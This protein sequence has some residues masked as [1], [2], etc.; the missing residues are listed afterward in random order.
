MPNKL[1]SGALWYLKEKH[2][3]VIP[4]KADKKPYIPWEKYQ[5]EHPTEKQ[6]IE[7]WETY[8]D[9]NV[10]I[11]TGAISDLTV[12]DLDSAAGAIAFFEH[13]PSNLVCPT[14]KSPKG[15]HL[16][17]RY[18]DGIRN[19]ARFL[20]DCDIRSEGG[21]I[22]APPSGINGNTYSWVAGRSIKGTT[23]PDLP[24]SIINI[25]YSYIEGM[26]SRKSQEVTE[27]TGD[28]QSHRYW[29]PGRRDD[30]LFT[31]ANALIKTSISEEF[32]RQTLEILIKNL[33]DDLEPNK[34]DEKIKSAIKRVH[35][36]EV[37]VM[38]EVRQWV[39]SQEGHFR[40]TECHT[41]SQYV[42]KTQKHACLMAILRLVKEGVL[43]KYGTQRGVY[44]K[45]ENNLEEIKLF[46]TSDPE[47]PLKWIAGFERY[48][49]FLPKTIY[50]IAGEP[51]AGK[52]ALCLN[53][54]L[55]N[56]DAMPVSYFS[57]EMIGDELSSRLLLAEDCDRR[58]IVERIKFYD[59]SVNFH[60]VIR[61]DD[62]NII[63][64]FEISKDFWEIADNLKDIRNKLNNGI[65]VIAIQKKRG[66]V[67]GRSAEFGLE[68]PRIYMT[69]EPYSPDGKYVDGNIIKIIK[70]KNWRDP[71][72]NPK[73]MVLRFKLAK[74]IN[75]YPKGSWMYEFE[76]DDKYSQF[77][78]GNGK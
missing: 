31:V 56:C 18:K 10:A 35:N 11:V 6:V 36:L 72:I 3:S 9:A 39:K 7:W 38:E 64:Y 77:K 43:E 71:S 33:G 24:I 68:K 58:K 22:I 14:V 46:E 42:T 59:R 29:E 45:V 48:I 37:N 12:V 4:C 8:P 47:L 27:V 19:R 73:D 50:V 17:F 74:G 5:K 40:V 57:S 49:R 60:D 28:H 54:A 30:D 32:T 52:S 23:V 67:L 26:V 53:L 20:P 41:E 2:Y 76:N 78:K 1:L 51:D 13:L 61:P 55:M 25:I 34:V 66:A 16:Y 65:A 21:Y 70:A 63:D 15:Q 75:I 69:V 62:L 44:R